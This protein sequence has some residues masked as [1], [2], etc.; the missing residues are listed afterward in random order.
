MTTL[1]T[2]RLPASTPTVTFTRIGTTTRATVSW[3]H[4]GVVL[5]DVCVMFERL[6]LR[7]ARHRSTDHESSSDLGS[8][9]EFDFVDHDYSDRTMSLIGEAFCAGAVGL[10][11][12]I[13]TRHW[14]RAPES[15]GAR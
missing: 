5:A 6:G 2:D 10:W 15:P 11:A 13:S 8:S 12:S 14:S 1:R 3:Q 4:D 7:V 9:D